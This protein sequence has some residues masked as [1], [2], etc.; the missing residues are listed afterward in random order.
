MAI[1]FFEALWMLLR[2]DIYLARENFASL[3]E[4]VRDFP[5]RPRTGN[6]SV[7]ERVGAAMDLACIWYWK[8]V[9]CLQRSSATA[10][11]L[12]RHGVLAQL[13]LGVQQW[14]F[15]AHAWVEVDGRVIN[16]KAYVREMYAVLDRC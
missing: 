5:T 13:V 15:R 10:C 6:A 9:Q 4:T 7:I 2:F 16:D 14:P 3:Y 1:L 11:L 12:R 8:E